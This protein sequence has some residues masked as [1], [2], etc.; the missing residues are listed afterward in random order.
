MSSRKNV[1]AKSKVRSGTEKKSRSYRS[2]LSFPVGRIHRFLRSGHYAPR[3]GAGASVYLSAVLEYLTAEILEL[4]GKACTDNV[5]TRIA[6]RHI[7]LAVRNDD[8]LNRM[9][10]G[11]TISQGGVIPHIPPQLLP[12]KNFMKSQIS[13]ATNSSSQ[14]Y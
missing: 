14:E 8:E 9:L 4:S 10:E 12:K 13:Q 7:L 11:V 3:I 2:G 6:P 5:R 1:S